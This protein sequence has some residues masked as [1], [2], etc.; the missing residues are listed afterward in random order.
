MKS[1]TWTAQLTDCCILQSTALLEF[2]MHYTKKTTTN[3]QILCTFQKIF[4]SRI[5]KLKLTFFFRCFA[6]CPAFLWAEKLSCSVV[7]APKNAQTL[8]GRHFFFT[9]LI[10]C[11]LKSQLS[12]WYGEKTLIGAAKSL[13]VTF[14]RFLG[15]G[16]ILQKWVTSSYT[17]IW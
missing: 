8:I 1:S 6:P 16:A 2:A 9:P 3:R 4:F 15:E 11:C 12:K 10:S 7:L 14:P 5:R 17:Q 13:E